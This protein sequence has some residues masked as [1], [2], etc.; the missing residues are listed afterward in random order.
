MD[1]FELKKS[2]GANL[3]KSIRFPIGLDSRIKVSII[4]LFSICRIMSFFSY[5]VAVRQM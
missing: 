5:A 4:F 1:N 2:K 3:Y